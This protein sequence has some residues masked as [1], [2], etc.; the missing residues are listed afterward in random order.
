[1]NL[2]GYHVVLSKRAK[3]NLKKINKKDSH[4]FR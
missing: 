2:K 3:R 1:M 4:N